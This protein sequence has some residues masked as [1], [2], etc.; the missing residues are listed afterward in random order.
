MY[1]NSSLFVSTLKSCALPM[2]QSEDSQKNSEHNLTVG[3]RLS[4]A[5]EEM[6][7]LGYCSRSL[8][9]YLSDYPQLLERV[10][11]VYLLRFGRAQFIT[12]LLCLCRSVSSVSCCHMLSDFSCELYFYWTDGKFTF[13][14][15][16]SNPKPLLTLTTILP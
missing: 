15:V 2:P 9:N 16:G 13:K 3:K 11:C 12:L 4:N 6:E 10:Q 5:F 1:A 8:W 14:Y 7:G